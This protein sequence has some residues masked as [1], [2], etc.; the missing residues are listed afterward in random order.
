MFQFCGRRYRVRAV[1]HKT[2]ETAHK[3]WQG[4]RLRETVHLAD[5]RCDGAAHG[6]CEAACTLYWKDV[7]LRRVGEAATPAEPRSAGA[8]LTEAQLLAATRRAA[9]DS[10]GE[11]CYSCQAT[12]IYDATAPL[13]W[14]NLRQYVL[15][16]S[17]GNHSLGRVICVLFLSA[18]REALRR[19]PTAWRV[20]NWFNER[21]HLWLTGRPAPGQSGKIKRGQRTPTE[22][23]D[24]K[25]GDLVRIKSRSEIDAT[26]DQFGRNRGLSFD[27]EEMAPYCGG[28]YRVRSS[29][30]QILDEVTGKMV[31]MKQ[32][33]IILEGVYCRSE[34]AGCRL[35]CPRAIPCYWREIWLERVDAREQPAVRPAATDVAGAMAET[36]R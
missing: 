12:Q 24:L 6:G 32:P 15:D 26:V 35:N 25:P 34:Y 19:T 5:L 28:V 7:W 30:K 20:V 23:L 22:R 31:R 27:P 14:W 13:A 9:G 10:Q 33:C 3:T 8:I 4:R 17:T 21:M 18:C 1:A 16:V 11:P 36:A 29:V 2:C